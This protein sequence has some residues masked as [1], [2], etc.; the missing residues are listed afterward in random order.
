M[1]QQ[2]TGAS[3]S[4]LTSLS[5]LTRQQRMDADG[6][7]SDAVRK[8]IRKDVTE[9]MATDPSVTNV[10]L[11]RIIDTSRATVSKVLAGN[12]SHKTADKYLRRFSQWL[13]NRKDHI[14]LPEARYAATSIGERILTACEIAVDLPCV[15]LISTPSGWGKTSALRRAVSRRGSHQSVYVQAGEACSTPREL[16]IEIARRL[17]LTL[18]ARASKEVAYREVLSNLAGKYQGGK[19]SSFL[20]VIDEAT[21]LTSRA[22]NMLRNLHDDDACRPAI[23]LADTVSRMNAFLYSPSARGIAGGNEQLRSRGKAQYIRSASDEIPPADVKAVA[24]ATLAELGYKG[25]LPVRTCKYLTQLAAK[26]GALRNVTAR[27][28]MLR[29]YCERKGIRPNYSIRQL[30]AMSELAGDRPQMET[31][32][33]PFADAQSVEIDAA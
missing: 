27:L 2:T 4:N 9:I 21:T 18:P 3:S 19:T 28:Q 15:G 17:G 30:D 26:P 1:I 33:T 14:E 23:V 25:K 16:M 10:K 11:G 7:L 31:N 22:I 24:E 5:P 6:L 29:Y 12:Y 13:D 32:P 20:I 8:Q